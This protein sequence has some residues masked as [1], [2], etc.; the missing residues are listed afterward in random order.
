MGH[1]QLIADLRAAGY[2][3]TVTNVNGA[4][5]IV[6]GYKVPVG[7]HAGEAIQVGLQAPDWPINPPGGPHLAPRIHHPGDNAHHGSPLGENFIYWSRPHPRW[8]DSS[9]TLPE[10]LAHLR[11]LFAQFVEI[12]A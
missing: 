4:E 7:A 1:E 5:F 3:P 6:F 11:A 10:Y 9:R 8:A 2:E 12:A